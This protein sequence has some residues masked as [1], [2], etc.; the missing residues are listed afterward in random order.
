MLPATVSLDS[1]AEHLVMALD[2]KGNLLTVWYL[3]AGGGFYA[4][5]CD[6]GGTC[7]SVPGLRVAETADVVAAE[8]VNT[9]D[10]DFILIWKEYD[11]KGNFTIRSGYFSATYGFN[12]PPETVAKGRERFPSASILQAATP[13]R[14]VIAWTAR[15]IYA[16][17]YVRG[18]GW[19]PTHKVKEMYTS[20][21]YLNLGAAGEHVVITWQD[22]NE[23]AL[24]AITSKKM[25]H[26]ER[27]RYLGEEHES[28]S[29]V[30]PKMLSAKP[31]ALSLFW[32]EGSEQIWGSR[33]RAGK[34]WAQVE[35]LNQEEYYGLNNFNM[36]GNGSKSAL[37]LFP[38]FNEK[39]DNIVIITPKVEIVGKMVIQSD[40]RQVKFAIQYME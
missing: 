35:R 12:T 39:I 5:Y 25:G 27:E 20:P 30:W 6:E 28:H 23:W 10:G 13:E 22:A 36:V 7:Q 17:E 4:A 9:D 29:L 40:Y 32:M 24:R 2:T 14:I 3:E 33:Y 8:I 37:L 19:A 21:K 15:N 1:A 26:W 38:I 34:G 18:S 31:D 16:R 11:D